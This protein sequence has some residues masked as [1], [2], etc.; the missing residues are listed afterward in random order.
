MRYLI[1]LLKL[2]CYAALALVV[3]GIG[4]IVLVAQGGVCSRL[5]EG[6]VECISPF[7]TNLGMFGL[8]VALTLVLT[9]LPALLGIVFLIRDLMR[10]RRARAPATSK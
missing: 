7:Y 10:W 6:A 3:A 1:L 8:T 5:D 4:A 2:I 9:G